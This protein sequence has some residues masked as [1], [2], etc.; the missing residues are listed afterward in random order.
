MYVYINGKING[1]SVDFI[2]IVFVLRLDKDKGE[3]SRANF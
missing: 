3:N 1:K 2:E